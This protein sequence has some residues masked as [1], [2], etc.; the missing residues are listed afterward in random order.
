MGYFP[1]ELFPNYLS[2]GADQIAWGGIAKPSPNGMSPPL[3]N[4]HKPNSNGEYNEACYIRNIQYITDARQVVS[5][6]WDNTLSFVS[7]STC[8]ELNPNENCGHDQF[9]YCFTFGGPGGY[10]CEAT[11]F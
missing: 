5:P 2:N 3:G 1:N 9:K 8:Y 7:N 11:I 6:N 10:N 4:G